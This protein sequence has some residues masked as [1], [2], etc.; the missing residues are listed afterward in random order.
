MR[1]FF[2]LLASAAAAYV[3]SFILT[4]S[5]N[6]EIRVWREVDQR[7]KSDVA[8]TRAKAPDQPVIIFTGGSSTAFSIDP[9]I[10][11]ESCGIPAFNFALP[12]S[13]GP[14]YLLHQAL[15]RTRPGDTLVI[16][17]EAD[18]LAF[19]SDYPASMFSFGLALLEGEPSATVG[20]ESFGE[21]LT[22]PETL[23]LS[24]P[25]PRYLM[26]LAYRGALGKGYR[27]TP[28]DY[29]YHGRMQTPVTEPGMTPHH[30][31]GELHLSKSGE[32]LL[33][34]FRNA[35]QQRGIR[36]FY[37]MPWRWT[38]PEHAEASR[39]AN[40]ALLRDI[41]RIV[42]VIDDGSRGVS[43]DRSHFSDSHQHLTAAGSQARSRLLADA[44]AGLLSRQ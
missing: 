3:L 12:A 18:F 29:Q 5:T 44:L 10:I 21:R 30:I 23:T 24:R 43:T 19:E 28:Q 41:D 14:R 8:E 15:E 37:A 25:G 40:A 31:E 20:G 2:T 34:T 32:H 13:A 17:L 6:P 22:L 27:Y 1:Y 35:A 11:E 9:A 42:P 36:L 4:V 26:T 39:L 33:R 16:G 7:R 38:A